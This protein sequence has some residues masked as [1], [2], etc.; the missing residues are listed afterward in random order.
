MNTWCA[1]FL[2]LFY[3]FCDYNATEAVNFTYNNEICEPKI[4]SK[5]RIA[6][7]LNFEISFEVHNIFK[8]LANNHTNYSTISKEVLSGSPQIFGIFLASEN[9]SPSLALN[10]RG[11]LKVFPNRT[12]ETEIFWSAFGNATNGWNPPFRDCV[13]LPR[14]WYHLYV[15]KHSNASV[16]VFI[17]LKVNQCDPDLEEIFG[18]ADKCDRET[19]YVSKFYCKLIASNLIF[20]IHEI[21]HQKKKRL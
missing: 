18:G 12:I 8:S 20:T 15:S 3:F 5:P 19:T 13:L 11:R 21:P 6:T 9:K 4:L 7:N 14:T 16:G 17:P 10:L 2:S 1:L